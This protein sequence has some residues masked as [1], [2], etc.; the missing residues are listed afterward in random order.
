MAHQSRV[1]S[2]VKPIVSAAARHPAMPVPSERSALQ[3]PVP[4]LRLRPGKGQAYPSSE[5]CHR[6]VPL[7]TTGH[8]LSLQMAMPRLWK[9]GAY[10]YVYKG[11]SKFIVNRMFRNPRAG[12]LYSILQIHSATFPTLPKAWEASL[13]QWLPGPLVSLGLADGKSQRSEGGRRKRLRYLIPGSP[14][15]GAPQ[16]KVIAPVKTLSLQSP[17]SLDSGNC[18]LLLP[19]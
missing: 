17:L 19:L 4:T 2:G 10:E 14:S 3:C 7:R 12:S 15:C 11:V 1:V 13:F 18:C 16:L 5:R 9:R 6:C 8:W